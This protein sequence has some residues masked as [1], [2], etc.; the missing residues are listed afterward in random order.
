MTR[1]EFE[2]FLQRLVWRDGDAVLA[3]DID[4]L[5]RMGEARLNR[6]LRALQRV[7]TATYPVTDGMAAFPDDFD[8]VRLV[9]DGYGAFTYIT[10]AEFANRQANR[11]ANRLY[12]IQGNGILIGGTSP[13]PTQIN[14]TYYAKLPAYIDA[15][16]WVQRDFFDLYTHACLIHTAPYLREDDRLPQWE[17]LYD[18][19]LES[20]MSAD[21]AAKYNGSPLKPRLPGVVA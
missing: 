15:E 3:A 19:N 13:M 7:M 9:A 17:A 6:D 8:H 16:T 20:A 5:I 4:Y 18:K 12:T 21:A 10:V 1:A 11:T 14:L 2:A